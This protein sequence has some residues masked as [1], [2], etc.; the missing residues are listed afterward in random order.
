MEKLPNTWY[1]TVTKENQKV[2]SNWRFSDNKTKLC[3]NSVTGIYGGYSTPSKEH[4]RRWDSNWK[5][6]ITFTQ[7][8]KW[9]LNEIVEPEYEIY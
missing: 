9:V 7:F 4:D 2:L 8:R 6:E 1:I 3:I 5:N